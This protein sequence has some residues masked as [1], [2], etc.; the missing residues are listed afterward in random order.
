MEQERQAAASIRDLQHML[1]RLSLRFPQLPRLAETGVFDEAT[2]EAVMVFQRDFGL[3]V[4]G[5]VDHNTWN[6]IVDAYR[7]DLLHYGAP[8]P[9][10]VLPD[11][12]FRAGAGQSGEP[13]RIAQAMLCAL[14]NSLANFPQCQTSQ[15]NE[16]GTLHDFRQV[17]KLAGLPETGELNR[18][19]WEFLTRLY[20]IYI[21]R[22]ILSAQSGQP[23]V[24][25]SS[26]GTGDSAPR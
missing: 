16:G 22:D 3:P 5:T 4:T 2:L 11:G 13:V 10:R 20:H 18:A 26:P 6:A 9:L 17:Q 12:A 15:V 19:T 8:A 25:P 24:S 1:D 21:A 23:P 7:E 14:S